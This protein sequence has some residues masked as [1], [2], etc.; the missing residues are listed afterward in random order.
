MRHPLGLSQAHRRRG[1]RRGRQQARDRRP[2]Q[3]ADHQPRKRIILGPAGPCSAHKGW[4]SEWAV[5]RTPSASGR[6]LG[7]S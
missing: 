7:R 2:S 5:N 1:Y 3:F 4:Q 6:P